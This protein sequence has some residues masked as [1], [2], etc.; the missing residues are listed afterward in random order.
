[1]FRLVELTGS[2][3]PK[4]LAGLVQALGLSQERVNADLM[5]YKVGA[6]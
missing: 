4:S 2:K 6:G 1:M 3:D 5:T